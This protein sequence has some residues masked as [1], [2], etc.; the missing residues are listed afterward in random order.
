M[1]S[2]IVL[3]AKVEGGDVSNVLASRLAHVAQ[4]APGGSLIVVTGRDECSAMRMWLEKFSSKNFRVV[5]EGKAKSTNENL[6]NSHALF[7][8]EPFTV[9]TSTFHVLR[10]RLWVQHLGLNY[11]VVGAKTPPRSVVK[12]YVRE[13]FAIIH[14]VLRIK[15]RQLRRR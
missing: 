6:E 14:S 9:V 5:E 7:P 12:M 11:T 10:T 13:G 1:S 3:G 4:I 2:F 15:W 8:A